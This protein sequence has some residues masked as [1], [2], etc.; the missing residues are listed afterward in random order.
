M[1]EL[2]QRMLDELR[3]R[4]YSPRTQKTY[5]S[6]VA[7]FARHFGKSPAD[8][9]NDDVRA[10]HLHLVNIKSSSAAIRLAVCALRFLYKNV[11]R[12]K[13]EVPDL[14]FGRRE[15]TLPVVLSVDEMTR[16]FGTVVNIKHKAILM[17]VYAAGLRV[18]EVVALRIGDIDSSRMVINV[19]QAKGKRD[20]TVMLAESLLKILREYWRAHRPGND[21]LF[22]S[23][24]SHERISARSVQKIVRIAAS[25]A[26]IRKR[27]TVHTLRHSF[28]THLSEAGADLRVIQVLLGHTSYNTTMRYVHVSPERL[29]AT[30]SP[31]DMMSNILKPAHST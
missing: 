3:I 28:A 4:N 25:R 26:G 2:R 24:R 23:G 15:H 17:T 9:S 14:P 31:L 1:T 18:S 13:E 22:P 27:V 11:L 6:H 16:L 5:I 8:L 30:P 20:R 21:Y 19:R 12:R 29:A 10:Y 7:R